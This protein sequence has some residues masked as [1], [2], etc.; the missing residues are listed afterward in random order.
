MDENDFNRFIEMA[1]DEA[2]EE[3][4]ERMLGLVAL[5]AEVVKWGIDD[6]PQDA[7]HEVLETQAVAFAQC[8]VARDLISFEDVGNFFATCGFDRKRVEVMVR[9]Y[10]WLFTPER[11]LEPALA[12]EVEVYR[13]W[14]KR[15]A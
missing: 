3:A 4:N 2:V 10:Y 13:K 11:P 9:D 15:N 7:V 14:G 1:K 5:F 12:G 8:A 6:Y